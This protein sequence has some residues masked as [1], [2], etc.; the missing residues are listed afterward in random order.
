[1]GN[2]SA[3]CGLLELQKQESPDI[4][5]LSETKMDRKR[6]ERFRWMLNIPNLMVKDCKGLSGGLALFWSKE[7]NLAV[8]S[9]S[10]YHI[11]A[12]VKDDDGREWR[13]TGMYG[14]PK[15]EEKDKTWILLRILNNKYKKPWLCMGDFF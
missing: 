7:I 14:E 1:L 11:D 6:M 4:L 15:V 2:A 12:V 9:F 13:F 5:F 10:R 8:K 3:V